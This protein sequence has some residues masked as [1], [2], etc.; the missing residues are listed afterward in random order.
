[1]CAAAFRNVV[2]SKPIGRLRDTKS[3]LIEHACRWAEDQIARGAVAL[4]EFL[5]IPSAGNVDEWITPSVARYLNAND[6]GGELV[7]CYR[8]PE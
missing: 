7:T 1:L 2:G 4:G 8:T 3:E 6:D 5:W